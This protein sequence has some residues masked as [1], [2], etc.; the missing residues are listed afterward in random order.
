MQVMKFVHAEDSPC[1]GGLVVHIN[2]ERKVNSKRE[3]SVQIDRRTTGKKEPPG[4]RGHPLWGSMLDFQRD[5]LAFI[6]DV[7]RQHGE[8]AKYRIANLTFYQVN[9]PEGVKRVL[10]DNYHNYVK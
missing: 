8:V 10:Q 2:K 4:P 6:L 1:L 7:A 9:H 3:A 5:Q